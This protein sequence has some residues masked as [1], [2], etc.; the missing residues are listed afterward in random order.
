MAATR[1]H[2]F[3]H[4]HIGTN[5]DEQTR[6]L[7]ALGYE[8][9][10][11]LL[12]AAVPESIQLNEPLNVP[13]PLT[14]HQALA[15]LRAIADRNKV[16]TSLIGAGWNDCITPPVIRRNMIENPAWYTS[17]TPYQPEISQGR[18]EMLLTFQTM[19]ADIVGCEIANASLLDEATAAAEA[20][21][22]LR[23]IGRSKNSAMFVDENCHPQTIDVVK[24]RAEPLG[25][26]L[27]IGPAQSV[28]AEEIGGRIFGA[29]LAYPGSTGEVVDLRPLID[30]VHEAGALVA[31][32]TDL[33]ACCVLTPPGEM[34]ADIVVGSAQRFG[35]PMGFGG[36]NAGFMATAD[37]HVRTMPGRL[38]GVSI[39]ADGRPA[40]RLTLQTR[41]QHIRREKATSNI[42]TAQALLANVAAAYGAWHGPEGLVE[43]A[44]RVHSLACRF[45]VGAE[46]LGLA[47]SDTFFDTVRVSVPSQ[48][49]DLVHAAA[50][51]EINLRL[52][53]G[54]SVS[55]SF[56]ETSTETLVDR[57][58]GVLA[59]ALGLNEQT[60]EA[61]AV[62]VKSGDRT[63]SV[64]PPD[65]ARTSEFMTHPN[66][67]M[68][69]T[70]TEMMRW[71]RRLSDRD[72]ALDRTMIPLGSCTMKLNAAA[73]MEP[74]TW[75]E[76]ASI[77][78]YAPAD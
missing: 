24:T 52:I 23:R 66:F 42:C 2:A 61:A 29:L 31:V 48:A 45:A 5:S 46:A 50:Q 62:A 39:D 16:F 17:Y 10:S 40:Y 12:E 19:V 44:E 65:L 74:I 75:P 6:M 68:Y 38:V 59:N 41:E 36:P 26:E 67:S 53:D 20:M 70:E 33:L 56:D 8:S 54:D 15:A 69:R 49:E 11:A 58:L 7:A 32:T 51:A 43:I 76:F 55:V 34:G 22:M 47:S 57:L 14:E 77:H 73:E 18:L 35:V 4:R 27:L 63:R 78:P 25:I 30:G 13:G 21:T 71:L 1:T 64:L 3:P 9:A 72:L 37:K 28:T 60:R